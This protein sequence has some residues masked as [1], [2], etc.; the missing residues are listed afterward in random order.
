MFIYQLIVVQY[1]KAV[2]RLPVINTAYLD[3][4]GKYQKPRQVQVKLGQ[5]RSNLAKYNSANIYDKSLPVPMTF[6]IL[7]INQFR[8]GP[9][10]GLRSSV[11]AKANTTDLVPV[12]EPILNFLINDFTYVITNTGKHCLCDFGVT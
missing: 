9:V 11:L 2:H 8:T 6:N 5:Y 3:K 12:T 7:F 1:L 10:T 4:F